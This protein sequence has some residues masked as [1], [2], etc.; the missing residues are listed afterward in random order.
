MSTNEEYA[1]WS[2]R[3]R[4]KIKHLI[5]EEGLAFTNSMHYENCV[6][7]S[8]W[9]ELAGRVGWIKADRLRDELLSIEMEEP[10]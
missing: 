7:E 2:E 5:D 3:V 4:A 6:P 1:A 10:I 8:Q 9:I